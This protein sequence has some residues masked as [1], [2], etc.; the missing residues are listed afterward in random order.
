MICEAPLH[1]KK[2]AVNRY[3]VQFLH[4]QML[5]T[6]DKMLSYSKG[7]M[8][9]L[10]HTLQVSLW[11]ASKWALGKACKYHLLILI[12]SHLA[13]FTTQNILKN[14]KQPPNPATNSCSWTFVGR[15]PEAM[16]SM[17]GF[18]TDFL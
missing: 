13:F 17:F 8:G 7:K 15:N 5:F 1:E 16:G 6:P 10:L 14:W 4:R 2:Q 9:L 18:I 11:T 12:L 3:L